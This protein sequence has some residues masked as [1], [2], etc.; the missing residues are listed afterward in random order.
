MR[1]HSVVNSPCVFY[2]IPWDPCGLINTKKVLV[3]KNK[4]N[5]HSRNHMK[6]SCLYC[7]YILFHL[8][9]LNCMGIQNNLRATVLAE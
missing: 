7:N 2:N 6:Q 4:Q 8:N 3:F 9:L 1:K 5:L